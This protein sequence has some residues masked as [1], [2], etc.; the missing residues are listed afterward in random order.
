MAVEGSDLAAIPLFG[1]LS[2]EERDELA[3]WFE[4]RT[5]DTGAR[6]VGEGAAGYEFF[7]LADGGAVVTSNG[8]ELT[9]LGPGDFFGEIAFGG[10]GRRSATVTSTSPTRLLCMFGTRYRELQESHGDI[11]AQIEAQCRAR[12]ERQFEAG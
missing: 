9:R 10:G 1:T 11:A 5:Y 7:V 4:D 3:G 6:L 8:V 2:S 12:L